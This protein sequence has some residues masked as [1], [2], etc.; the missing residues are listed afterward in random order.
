MLCGGKTVTAE[1]AHP[2]VEDAVMIN[3]VLIC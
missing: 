1:K 2:A 3:Q